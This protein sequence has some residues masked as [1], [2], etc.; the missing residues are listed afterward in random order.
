MSTFLNINGRK[1]NNTGVIKFRILLLHIVSLCV[2][3]VPFSYP[4]LAFSILI[5]FIRTFAWEGGSHRYFS[6]KSYKTSRIFQFVLAVIAASGGQRGPLWWAWHHR[7]HHQH[8]D[9]DLDLHSP[10]YKSFWYAHVGWII[11]NVDFDPEVVKDWAKYPELVWLTKHHYI[12][13]YL[14]MVLF[15]CLG[16]YTNIFGSEVNGLSSAVWGAFL[17]TMLSLH[18][19]FVVNTITHG[20]RS[21]WFSY[22][23]FETDDSSINNWFLAIPTMG[24][25]WH[26]NHHRYMN[27]ARAGIRW[28][29]IDLTFYVL[30]GLEF[31]GIVWD[32][33]DI[34]KTGVVQKP[35][36]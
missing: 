27:S 34:P 24:A 22:R 28:W 21:G 16:Q 1:L 14:S 9:T 29:E 5:F 4:L 3:F 15:F 32:V 35:L 7:L 19:T 33:R 18:A 2:F 31:L 20:S 8:S 6:H 26:N 25:S 23:S 13:P 10:I 17:T 11:E 12:F 36:I 30:K